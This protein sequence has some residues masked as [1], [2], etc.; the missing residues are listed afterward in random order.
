[1]NSM[2]KENILEPV[3]A[4]MFSKNVKEGFKLRLLYCGGQNLQFGGQ[5]KNIK[6]LFFCQ[7]VV[8]HTDFTNLQRIIR[9]R[10]LAH[11]R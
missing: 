9:S 4:F 7:Y 1:M 11:L 10:K 8:S 5:N 6:K 3:S 2:Y